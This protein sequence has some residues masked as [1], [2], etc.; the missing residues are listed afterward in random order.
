MDDQWGWMDSE[1]E[2]IAYQ[3]SNAEKREL[4]ITAS[5]ICKIRDVLAAVWLLETWYHDAKTSQATTH[6]KFCRAH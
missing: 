2:E 5:A 1:V 6:R 4:F 3:E